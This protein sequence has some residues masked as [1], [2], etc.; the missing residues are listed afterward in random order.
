MHSSHIKEIVLSPEQNKVFGAIVKKEN[1]L[2]TGSAGTGKSTL[3]DALRKTFKDDLHIT[4]STGI[5]AVNVSG[6]TVHRWAGITPDLSAQD[7]TDTVMKRKGAAFHRIRTA[8]MLAIDEISMVDSALIDTLD[9]LFKTV[10]K[11][12]EPFG[13]VQMILFGDF[14][15]LPPV[16]GSGFAFQSKAWTQA[17]IQPY[18]LT[19]VFRQADKTFSELLNQI[20]VG[21]LTKEGRDIL[22]SR[23][24]IKPTEKK[25]PVVV[26]THNANADSINE[27]MLKKLKG[28]AVDWKAHDYGEPGPMKVI[29]KNCLAPELLKLKKGAQVMCLWNLNPEDGIANGSIGTVS[30]IEDRIPYVEFQNGIL[31]DMERKEWQMRESGQVIAG[32]SQLPL[33]LA[34][35]ITSHKCQGM[36][37]DAIE[38]FLERCFD[39]GQTYV[40]LSRARTLEG[41]YIGSINYDMIRAHPDALKF[42]E[43]I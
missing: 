29:Q 5:A 12:K 16:K 8:K 13:G 40:A 22:Q 24:G 15:Q 1:V 14:L 19:E 6:V 28:K 36:T 21:N 31:M 20:R 38:V 9:L 26:H 23:T 41:L 35:A 43:N 37:L 10:R 11:S 3:L 2:V 32:R 7:V 30:S 34:W 25:R 42:Y 4:A 33:R 27:Q 18:R 17:K 39:Y